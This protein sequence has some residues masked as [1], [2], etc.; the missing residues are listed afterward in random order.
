MT[1][2][3]TLAGPDRQT[4]LVD[5]LLPSGAGR[6]FTLSASA[7]LV[8]A[9]AGL[10][11]DCAQVT[12]PW[13]PVPFTGQTFGVLL[14]GGVLGCRRG[15]LAMA[16]YWA[17]IAV[18]LPLMAGAAGGWSAVSSPTGG[19]VLGFVLAA[20][21]VGALCQWGADRSVVTL[22]G[23]LLLGEAAVFAVGVP[24]LA[25]SEIVPGAGPLG[26]AGAYRLGLEPFVLGDLAKLAAVSALLSA[27][28]SLLVAR[29]S[30]VDLQRP[31]LLSA[32][33]EQ[34]AHRGPTPP[35]GRVRCRQGKGV[36]ISRRLPRRSTAPTALLPC[37]RERHRACERP[38][39][40]S[41][42]APRSGMSG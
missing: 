2:V 10:V 31:R 35:V 30:G 23:A 15:A 4:T 1:R 38:T 17:L 41:T 21:L 26:L 7:T 12:I 27:S 39:L 22:V 34:F 24:W 9:R 13:Y 6:G 18:G 33:G 42:E 20:A 40:R 8:A 32:R 16:L 37:S 19:Y 29:A 14:V 11:A 28:W 25:L 3:A 36:R 5:H